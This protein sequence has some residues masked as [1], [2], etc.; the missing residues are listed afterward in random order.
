MKAEIRKKIMDVLSSKTAFVIYSCLIA[1]I[2][3]IVFSINV[4]PTTVRTISGISVSVSLP[5]TSA[6]SDSQYVIQSQSVKNIDIRIEANRSIINT[7]K[8]EDFTAIAD[9]TSMKEPGTKSFSISV[10]CSK[11]IDYR[12]LSMSSETTEITLDKLAKKVLDIQVD[13]P[14]ITVADGYILENDDGQ[15]TPSTVTVTGP[16]QLLSQINTAKVRLDK[17]AEIS[18]S[19]TS[20]SDDLKFY[21]E[22]GSE[23]DSSNLSTDTTEFLVTFDIMTEKELN[24][25]YQIQ[26]MPANFDENFL[27]NRIKLSQDSITLATKGKALDDLKAW[28]IGTISLSDIGLDF[29]KTVQ[30]DNITSDIRNVSDLNSVT[31]TLDSTGLAEKEFTINDVTVSNPPAGYTDFKVTTD[32]IT[33]TMVG[34]EDELENLSSQDISATVNLTGYNIKSLNFQYDV[35]VSEKKYRNIW[36]TGGYKASVSCISENSSEISDED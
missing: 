32:S 7:L 2:I 31:M 14:G 4:F 23:I 35:T 5:E 25:T 20:Y 15:C 26:N 3:W 11:N 17:K 6:N 28:D 33:V 21:A 29:T 18:N 13:A 30:I 16:S 36:A 10:Q 34:P 19:Y 12:V 24:L 27:K 8:A 9:C 1:I 22:D